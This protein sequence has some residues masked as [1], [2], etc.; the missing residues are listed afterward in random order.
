VLHPTALDEASAR[1]SFRT[2]IAFSV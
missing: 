2:W 1:C